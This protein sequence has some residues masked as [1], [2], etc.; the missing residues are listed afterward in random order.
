MGIIR[1]PLSGRKGIIEVSLYKE[2]A[3]TSFRNLDAKHYFEA[4]VV[5]SI[6]LDVLLNTLPDRLLALSSEELT[7]AQKGILEEIEKS[8][9]TSGNIIQKLKRENILDRRLVR[10]LESLN[11]IRNTII[12]P[13][14]SGQ[15]KS[16]TVT[17]SSTNEQSAKK[18]FRLFCHVIDLAAGRSPYRERKDL[19][20]Y[21]RWRQ[22]NRA[23]HFP[24]LHK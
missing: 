4:V 6:G 13:F 15:I 19:D 5:C 12:H 8:K 16:E 21:I 7:N 17:P 11:E 14:Q 24:V 10:A 22:K 18:V 2:Y 9:I 20:E 1:Y 23:L 3:D